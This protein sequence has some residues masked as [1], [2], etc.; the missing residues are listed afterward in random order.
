VDT[1]AD[2]V[3]AMLAQEDPFTGAHLPVS[4]YSEQLKKRKRHVSSLDL[5][6]LDMSMALKHFHHYLYLRK[7]TIYT[8]HKNLTG[9]NTISPKTINENRKKRLIDV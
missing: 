7:F 4:F 6:L 9:K 5:E 3:G 2:A 1:S 8:D